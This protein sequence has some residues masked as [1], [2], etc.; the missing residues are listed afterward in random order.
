[1]QL[2]I[3]RKTIA[4]VIALA[5]LMGWAGFAAVSGTKASYVF[6]PQG[7]VAENAD[8]SGGTQ[9]LA[10]DSDGA[11]DSELAGVAETPL[12]KQGV[13][14]KVTGFFKNI[15]PWPHIKGW[16]AR[17]RTPATAGQAQ[18]DS[19]DS[20]SLS[21][22][23]DS[24]GASVTAE[25][26]P[27]GQGFGARVAGFFKQPNPWPHVRGWFAWHRSP[28]PASQ[29]ENSLLGEQPLPPATDGTDPVV[30]PQPVKQSF[31]AS[32]TGF[33]KKINP[34]PLLKRW[35]SWQRSPAPAAQAPETGVP[36]PQ[37]QSQAEPGPA[38]EAQNTVPE[39]RDPG[40]KPADSGQSRP[41]SA[42]GSVSSV[43][44]A[45]LQ[46]TLNIQAEVETILNRWLAEGRLTG[47]QGPQGA[48]GPAGPSVPGVSMV[49]PA[50]PTN[51]NFGGILGAFRYLS[52]DETVTRTLTVSET[53]LLQGGLTVQGQ[54]TFG[55]TTISS[56]TVNGGVHLTGALFDAGNASGTSG[57]LLQS[58]GAGTQWV[59]TS[60]FLTSNSFIQGG[61]SF[62]AAA[63]LG[64]TDANSLDLRT[65]GASRLFISSNG[66][67]GIGTTTPLALLD[68]GDGIT[69]QDLLY[70]G[71]ARPWKFT[72]QGSGGSTS[73]ILQSL[74]AGKSFGI[75]S[76]DST[77]L[78]NFTANVNASSFG[79]ASTSVIG[80]MGTDTAL[81]IGLSRLSVNKIAVGNG[82]QGD[83]T[84]TLIA[85]NVGIGTTSPSATLA[86]SGTGYFSGSL[87]TGDATTTRSNLGLT[88]ATDADVVAG[89]YI[90][91]WGDSLTAG[92]GGTPYPS[93]LSSILNNR[94]IYNGGVSGN[95]SSQIKARMLAASDKYSYTAIIW[96]GRND[97]SVPATVKA[98]I[99]AMVAALGHNRY[100]ILSVLNG[101][102]EPSG[103]PNYD[104]LIQLNTDLAA[105]YPNNYVDIRAYLVSQYD[106]GN[107]QDVID[108]GN[109][110][111][112]SSLRSDTLHLN[113][114]GYLKVAE[115]LNTALLAMA[116]SSQSNIISVKNTWPL[117]SLVRATGTNLS[118]GSD[119]GA[120]LISGT[121]NVALG[122][123]ALQFAT[124]TSFN[125]AV[126]V[127]ALGMG[128]LLSTANNTGN[129]NT[130][131]GYS[132]L[133]VVTT[134]SNNTATGHYALR[135]NTTGSNNVANGQ[136]ALISNTTGGN[137]VAVG[138]SAL[139]VNTTGSDNSALGHNTLYNNSASVSN[140][141]IGSLSAFGASSYTNQG[142]VTIGY[143]SGQG[144]TTGSNYNT[145]IG[146]QS[147]YNVSSGTNNILIGATPTTANANITTGANNILIGYNISAT[148]SSASGQLNIGNLIYGTGLTS[149][150]GGT[151][152]AGNVGI[153]TTGPS[154]QL[155][156]V[157]A[158]NTG[159][160]VS[161]YGT[162]VSPN[163]DFNRGDGTAGSPSAVLLNDSLGQVSWF[164]YGSS[165]ISS[166]SRA[167][168]RV[169]AAENWTD[170]AQG[171]NMLF[172][173]TPTGGT[174]R[175]E[176]M[177]ITSQGNVGIGTTSPASAL[178]ILN[179]TS[180]Q[181]RVAQAAAN[182][183]D[184]GVDAL[185][186]VSI[187]PSGDT[188]TMP[189]DNLKVCTGGA[190]P[191]VPLLAGTGNLV[192]EGSVYA[193][194]YSGVC[195]SGYVWV[196]G[197]AKFGTLPGFCAMKYEAKQSGSVAVSTPTGSPWVSITQDVSI[198]ACEANGPGY[199]LISDQEWMTIATNVATLPIN[200]LDA[201][202]SL[203]LATGHS[204]NSPAS[205]LAAT[206]GADPSV[207]GCSLMNNLEN[208]ANAYSAGSCE[209]RGAGAGG[210]TDADKGY[211]GTGQTWSDT[212]YS[213]GA[214][215][216]SQL[217]T[218]VLSNG[219]VIW[220][221][222]GNVWEWT[223][224]YLYS[225]ASSTASEMPDAGS[226]W[227]T[228]WYNYTSVTN[229]KALDYIRP[230]NSAWTATNGIGQIY[231]DADTASPS[232]NYHAFI[233]G[234][235]WYNGSGSGAFALILNYAPADTS[236]HIGFRCA[237]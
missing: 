190:C 74:T 209:L 154:Q 174:S 138:V 78:F 67:V 237:R 83:T 211:Y 110:V 12:V 1:M 203:Q 68:I 196:P 119:A 201:D 26:P 19:S 135:L 29:A 204:D 180:P 163:I 167:K 51:S 169:L 49:I 200:D 214:A 219:N 225:A 217:R 221:V 179:S 223:D 38:Q 109:D 198:A 93:Q 136:G 56:L 235:D 90:A 134:G 31:T 185:G 229:Y 224:K 212:G 112:P 61:N 176:V 156:L 79:A 143:R 64:T 236:S 129:S 21:A 114:A 230:R 158:G 152:V 7:A 151:P 226:S 147:G 197:N 121:Y 115:R 59:A 11:G 53:A 85:G 71:S 142:G 75:E 100:I 91:A 139:R 52:G 166:G 127:Q 170:S 206:G 117:F 97:Y 27:S 15:N 181:L 9:V 153:G 178:H 194:E 63:V 5:A 46:P 232:G 126:G 173:T 193:S 122:N 88:I 161:S 104:T 137:N 189:D 55:T 37:P 60:S 118:L 32:V 40:V 65:N 57:M 234:G 116:N 92:T 132:A 95:T 102:A 72:A 195:P 146:F 140:V 82:T 155:E 168:I 2:R 33:F 171:T 220:D 41:A 69:N 218:F 8:D 231:L 34:W 10:W 98:N 87:N 30:Q 128:T 81:D 94:L 187:T 165:T 205:A 188:M 77:L 62:G 45:V 227:S 125:T 113:T 192:V 86:V 3:R 50:T 124:S 48:T 149:A 159:L 162:G 183:T 58:T 43:S 148:S 99:A 6:Y 213:A 96:A 42:S 80:F 70:F 111:P 131:V 202:A 17:Q 184:I 89:T 103:N 186:N 120:N 177:R 157:N 39:I 73:L 191:T 107:P 208:A 228:N 210:S 18:A 16:F 172:E 106:P 35:F 4:I 182:F 36:A 222:A 23:A 20:A 150:G 14:A 207:S 199:H 215:N 130:A 101:T 22:A 233:R 76:S 160:R 13:T 175:A 105:L 84:G 141:A 25:T 28:A 144:F 164:G 44:A 133:S 108:F 47:P 54:S 24:G 66:N 145:L 216:K 123:G